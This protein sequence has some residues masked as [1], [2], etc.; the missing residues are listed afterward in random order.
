MEV[1]D[2]EKIVKQTF[3]DLNWRGLAIRTLLSV[4]VWSCS[5]DW[6]ASYLERIS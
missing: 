2:I 1:R 3:I 5:E 6:G 4:L